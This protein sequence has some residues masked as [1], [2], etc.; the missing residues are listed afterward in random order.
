M[1]WDAACLLVDSGSYNENDNT[2]TDYGKVGTVLCDM[3]YS[4]I[5][6]AVPDIN[7]ADFGFKVDKANNRIIYALKSIN[8]INT[9][10]AHNII[11]NR[12]FISMEDFYEK[13][14]DTK[15]ITNSQ[16]IML[17]KGGCFTELHSKDRT[18]TM[19]DYL[20]RYQYKPIEK[21][22][23]SQLNNIQELNILPKEY[24]LQIKYLNFKNYVL[25]E[26]HVIECV[27]DENK[28]IPKCGYHDRL[29]IL[30]DNSQPF[31]C[32]NMTEDCVV[33]LKAEFYVIS[34]KLFCKEIENKIQ[35]LRDWFGSEEGVT[36]YNNAVFRQTWDKNC[37]G[38]VPASD[39]I[40]SWYQQSLS[41]YPEKTELSNID[42]KTYGIVDF[43][44]LPEEP[45]VR[46]TYIRWI[47]GEQKEFPLYEITRLAGTVIK[48]DNMHYEISICTHTGQVVKVKFSSG[49]YNFYN[50]RLSKIDGKDVKKE[51]EKSWFTRGTK[52]II[53]GYRRGDLFIPKVYNTTVYKHTVNRILEIHNDGTLL[54]QQERTKI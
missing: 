4:G 54:V 49:Q 27:V 43:K 35:P 23:M 5:N 44:E 25:D 32:E 39:S 9:D 26:S 30:D 36:A 22:T 6:I 2:G 37:S 34:E 10:V 24:E 3:T 8:G 12:P 33:R 29:F 31:F 50:R 21:L 46:D 45:N 17:I 16:M 41:Y 38:K 11:D 18:K 40:E 42:T 47:G 28:K 52:L 14:I 7:K 53:S 13:M 51:I 48:N 20:M 15:L 1:Y 19:R